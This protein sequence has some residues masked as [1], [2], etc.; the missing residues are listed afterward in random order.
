[1]NYAAI[2]EKCYETKENAYEKKAF[3]LKK[4][5]S[6]VD[7]QYESGHLGAQDNFTDSLPCLPNTVE[8]QWLE[9]LWD[10]EN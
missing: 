6:W 8:L 3:F 4:G 5:L 2:E 7:I 1:M 9:H 10:H